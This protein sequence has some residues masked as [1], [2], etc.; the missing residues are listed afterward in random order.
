MVEVGGRKVGGTLDEGNISCMVCLPGYPGSPK[1]LLMVG[2]SEG[3]CM[4]SGAPA[5]GKPP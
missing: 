1:G 3:L 4:G 2:G 5:P